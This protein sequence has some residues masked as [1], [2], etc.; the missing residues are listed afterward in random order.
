MICVNWFIKLGWELV[1]INDFLCFNCVSQPDF[2]FLNLII[3]TFL[4]PWLLAMIINIAFWLMWFF[5]NSLQ[6]QLLTILIIC[7]VRFLGFDI[8][9]VFTHVLSFNYCSYLSH[10]PLDVLFQL[11]PDQHLCLGVLFLIA[12]F[13][14]KNYY[15]LS[16]QAHID[17]FLD[18]FFIQIL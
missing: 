10:L 16:R 13:H 17:F 7:H 3:L 2:L 15:V 14:T 4:R 11:L 9:L 12:W 6:E 5:L 8:T 1:F 18:L